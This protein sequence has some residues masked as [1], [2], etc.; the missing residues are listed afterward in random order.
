MN[1]KNLIYRKFFYILPYLAGP[2][3]IV[4]IFQDFKNKFEGLTISV[5][6]FRFI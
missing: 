5:G 1:I 3:D 6:Q 4:F 2:K